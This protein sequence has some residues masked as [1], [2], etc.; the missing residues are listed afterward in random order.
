[1][2]SISKYPFSVLFGFG[3]P[4]ILIKVPPVHGVILASY[5]TIV[6]V[7]INGNSFLHAEMVNETNNPK[8]KNPGMCFMSINF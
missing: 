3:W 2:L 7:F 1:M 4:S 8:T 6:A 5:P